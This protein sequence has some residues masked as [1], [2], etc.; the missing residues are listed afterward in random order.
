MWLTLWRGL[1]L[2]AELVSWQA[3]E[4]RRSQACL[5]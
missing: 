5:R 1:C 2:E 3:R 4:T